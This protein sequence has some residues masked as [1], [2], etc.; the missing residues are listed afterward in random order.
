MLEAGDAQ[1]RRKLFDKPRLHIL[2]Y[3]I[4]L[5][6]NTENG[7]LQTGCMPITRVTVRMSSNM[8]RDCCKRDARKIEVSSVRK[9]LFMFSGVYCSEHETK[10]ESTYK[11]VAYLVQLECC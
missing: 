11:N 8:C 2:L 7:E 5:L 4:L 9:S 3:Y 6:Y 1:N 10:C